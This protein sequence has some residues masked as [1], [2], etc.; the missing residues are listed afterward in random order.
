M[1]KLTIP[2]IP[3]GQM[4][5]RHTTFGGFSKTYKDKKQESREACLNAFLAQNA[6]AMPMEGELV[7]R[8]RCYMPMPKM[9]K[10]KTAA[11][12]SGEI[13]PTTKPD[14]DNLVK[15]LKDCLT[16]MRF[17]GDDKQVV[18]LVA[19]KWYSDRPRWEVEILEWRAEA[20]GPLAVYT[21]SD[22]QALSA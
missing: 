19:S 21:T 18:E 12:L 22:L 10:A 16:Q 3:V 11:A 9:T 14:L 5:A 1:I 7:L 15:H 20:K 17:W 2:I 8:V 4:R 6:P 13:R